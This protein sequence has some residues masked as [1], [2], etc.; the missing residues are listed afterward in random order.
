M[1]PRLVDAVQALVDQLAER[2]R[3]S[4]AVDD[5]AGNLIVVSRHYGDADPYRMRLML[6]RR[7]PPG[8][9]EY[10]TKFTRDAHGDEPIHVP[11]NPD[12]ALSARTCFPIRHD[13]DIIAFLWVIKRS[14]PLPED[15]IAKYCSRLANHLASRRQAPAL[16]PG[17]TIGATVLRLLSG[18]AATASPTPLAVEEHGDA[19]FVVLARYGVAA[20]DIH[21]EVVER[22]IRPAAR[23][24]ADVGASL[25]CTTERDGCTVAVF[26]LTGSSHRVRRDSAGWLEDEVQRIAGDSDLGS[27]FGI[28]PSKP[29][30]NVRRCFAKAALTAFV[31]AQLYRQEG[32]LTW[33]QVRPFAMGLLASDHLAGARV[34]SL[35]AMFDEADG[36]AFDTVAAV[37]RSDRGCSPADL[38]H[39]HRT[40]LHYRLQQITET[41]GLD[42][43]VPADRFL[44]FCA[45]LRAALLRSPVGALV[46]DAGLH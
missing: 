10:F 41:T 18:Q 14:R 2:I 9:R 23:N 8:Y 43:A 19:E 33:R 15:V 17:T 22:V 3:Q 5:P 29:L 30:R 40:T 27:A 36:F 32:V 16:D 20:Q 45:W 13:G 11:A 7:I 26:Q 12:L 37:L 38:L 4:V 42:L 35:N 6:D 34:S 46:D 44:V 28:S 39:V 21:D 25:A 24:A 31:G 1:H